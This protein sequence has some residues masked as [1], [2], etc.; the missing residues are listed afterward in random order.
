MELFKPGK[1][2]D[3]MSIRE[4][5]IGG[6]TLLSLLCVVLLFVPGPNYGTDFRGGTELEV[7]F[8]QPVPA[9]KVRHAVT[10]AGFSEPDVVEVRDATHP[11]RFI[12]RVQ[13]V[14]TVDDAA[15]E[16]VR[17]A[18][19]LGVEGDATEA[20]PLNARATEVGIEELHLAHEGLT[21]S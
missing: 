10:A 4:Y 17:K 14:S 16:T 7:A 20:C 3:F 2:Y 19:C 9:D 21:R 18:L 5:W 1:I 11:N 13:E 8:K 12:V 6:S 15:K